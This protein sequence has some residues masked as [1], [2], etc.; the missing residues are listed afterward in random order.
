MSHHYR[1]SLLGHYPNKS[2]LKSSIIILM[3][4][5]FSKKS[6]NN[7]H[8]MTASLCLSVHCA[9][10]SYTVTEIQPSFLHV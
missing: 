7:N 2:E 5:S 1:V 8:N 6:G 9:L 10:S 4:I 3:S